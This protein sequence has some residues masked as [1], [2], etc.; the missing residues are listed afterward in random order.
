VGFAFGDEASW[1][2]PVGPQ[3]INLASGHVDIEAE[4][5]VAQR[6]EQVRRQTREQVAARV[7]R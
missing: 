2:Q 7:V 6:K 1:Q 4:F 3:N 5:V